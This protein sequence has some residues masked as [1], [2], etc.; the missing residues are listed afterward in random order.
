[1][2]TKNHLMIVDGTKDMI[3]IETKNVCRLRYGH[4]RLP[5]DVFK[6]ELW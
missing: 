6:C 1:M 5:Q 2:K 3:E 4:G